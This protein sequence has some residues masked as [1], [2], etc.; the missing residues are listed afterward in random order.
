MSQL[1]IEFLDRIKSYLSTD[2]YDLFLKSLYQDEKKGLVLD[3]DKLNNDN[4]IINE[5]VNNLNL[6]LYYNNKNYNYYFYDETK[7]NNNKSIGNQ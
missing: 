1:P 4:S 2:N 7:I 6:E 5:I 3:I